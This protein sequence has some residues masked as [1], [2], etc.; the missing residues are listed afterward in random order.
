MVVVAAESED[1]RAWELASSAPPAALWR[2]WGA[3]KRATRQRNAACVASPPP[4]PPELPGAEALLAAALPLSKG[5]VATAGLVLGATPACW[6]PP[7]G[8]SEIQIPQR[9]SRPLVWRTATPLSSRVGNV[10]KITVLRPGSSQSDGMSWGSIMDSGT[11]VFPVIPH[12]KFQF[13][14]GQIGTQPAL[15][16]TDVIRA[17]EP[18]GQ[19]RPSQQRHDTALQE[20]A[21]HMH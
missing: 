1:S 13:V 20:I 10:A 11:K 14:P 4:T 16:P 3:P 18:A 12:Q 9:G 15:D 7:A 19:A 2:F 5:L 8:A 17:G 21:D 6:G